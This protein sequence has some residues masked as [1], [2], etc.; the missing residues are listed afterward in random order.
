[1]ADEGKIQSISR[2]ILILN[3]FSDEEPELK[4]Q[5]ICDRLDL[6]KSTAHGI[7]STLKYYGLI[8]QNEETQKYHLGFRI[9]ELG[10]HVLNRINIRQV[11]NLVL[12]MVCST[13]DETVHLGILDGND[14][15]YIDKQ[16]SQQS[17]PLRTT[18]GSRYPAYISSIGRAILSFMPLEEQIK[19][20]PDVITQYTQHTITSKGEILNELQTTK[21]RG[22]S[23]VNEEY[24]IGLCSVGAPIFDYKNDV[25]GAIST[26]GPTIRMTNGKLPEIASI[27]CQAAEKISRNLGYRIAG[28]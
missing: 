25:V 17:I 11:S 20:V 13:V 10:G 16:E 2:A 7:L 6:K 5:E 9:L 15:I 18:I 1:M 22:Y 24:L 23:I 19:R 4:L 3:I 26:S 28:I 12:K 21:I 8:G 14:V 27:I